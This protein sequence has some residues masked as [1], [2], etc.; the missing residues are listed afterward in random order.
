MDLLITKPIQ[1]PLQNDLNFKKIRKHV[2]TISETKPIKNQKNLKPKLQNNHHHINPVFYI[3][4]IFFI[5]FIYFKNVNVDDLLS[6]IPDDNNPKENRIWNIIDSFNFE[7]NS[8]TLRIII[9]GIRI[10]LTFLFMLLSSG[11]QLPSFIL[12][13]SS[14]ADLLFLKSMENSISYSLFCII[15]EIYIIILFVCIH[16]KK[17]NK[18]L[19]L[20]STLFILISIISSIRIEFIFLF[21]P[22]IIGFIGSSFT[23]ANLVILL[24]F[25]IISFSIMMFIDHKIGIPIIS[26]DVINKKELFKIIISS[27]YNLLIPVFIIT[28]FLWGFIEF[29]TIEDH[30][31][32]MSFLMTALSIF[33]FSISSI[34]LDYFIRNLLIHQ[35]LVNITFFIIAHQKIYISYMLSLIYLILS[36]VFAFLQLYITILP[37]FTTLF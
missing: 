29:I 14:I 11:K 5:V 7:V 4:L 34:F 23:I 3:A 22:L 37:K 2:L 35:I 19:F 33:C 13:V 18:K 36:F 20:V 10:S 27:D 6:L 26:F 24:C 17:E 1:R 15:F 25:I 16:S 28:L 32:L 8:S 31:L 30:L 12:S 21:I 9:Q